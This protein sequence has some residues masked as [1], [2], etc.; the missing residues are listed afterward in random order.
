VV[1]DI[2]IDTVVQHDWGTDEGTVAF[3]EKLSTVYAQWGAGYY[4]GT[5]D[6]ANTRIEDELAHGC[7]SSCNKVRFVI[8]RS[9]GQQ[10][11]LCYYPDGSTQ[12]LH[13][14]GTSTWCPP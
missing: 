6:T 12:S 4:Q 14:D 1:G 9:T 5:L 2:V 7:G 3:F 10:D 13:G 11:V 8:V